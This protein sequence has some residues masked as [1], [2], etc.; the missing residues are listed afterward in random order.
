MLKLTIWIP[1]Y[2]GWSNLINCIKSCKNINLKENEY[3]ILVIDNCSSDW[4]IENIE[5]LKKEINNLKLVKNESNLWRIW[6]WNEIIQK[7]NGNKLMFLFSNDMIN[8]DNNIWELVNNMIDKS[9]LIWKQNKIDISL[10]NI[11]SNKLNGWK[12]LEEIFIKDLNLGK[13][14]KKYIFNLSSLPF[15]PIQTIIFD[16]KFIIEKNL[17]FNI[18][19]NITWD[20]EFW[21]D[22]LFQ[23]NQDKKYNILRTNKTNIIFNDLEKNRTH[24]TINYYNMVEWDLYILIDKYEDF[25]FKKWIFKID[26]FYKYYSKVFLISIIKNLF[27]NKKIFN[28]FDKFDLINV[29]NLLKNK[30][31]LNNFNILLLRIFSFL[32][33]PSIYWF[34]FFWKNKWNWF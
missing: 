25:L 21:M 30:Y 34:Y 24:N 20:Q 33:F 2:N 8:E 26:V 5:L 10:K 7:S 31:G 28:N 12:K 6:N 29:E 27:S 9:I 14:L 22:F 15:W 3:E 4:S 11:I 18:N 17:L 32:N 1:N 23:M 13:L 19:N 16:K